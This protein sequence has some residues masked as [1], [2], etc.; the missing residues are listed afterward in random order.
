MEAAFEVDESGLLAA[1]EVEVEATA[2]VDEAGLLVAIREEA[3]EDKTVIVF[4]EDPADVEF[5]EA[6]ELST[7]KPAS[8][9]REGEPD[10]RPLADAESAGEGG[11]L[12]DVT[13]GLA[14]VTKVVEAAA[15]A[16][17]ETGLD[18]GVLAAGPLLLGMLM[19]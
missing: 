10:T 12:G 8:A 6:E 17:C 3:V 1:F 11:P 7:A 9:I 2:V 14:K 18:K 13:G 16:V 5:I 4:M 15:A 19:T